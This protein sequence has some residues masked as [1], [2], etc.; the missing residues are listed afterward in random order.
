[1]APSSLLTVISSGL[2]G[3]GVAKARFFAA[4]SSGDKIA[5]GLTIAVGALVVVGVPL[6]LGV[7]FGV[8]VC[9]VAT[10]VLLS[11]LEALCSWPSLHPVK[12]EQ[13]SRVKASAV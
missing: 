1:M 6:P 5:V 8:L 2:G 9:A 4:S 11:A 7:V 10:A 12:P 3:G 13:T